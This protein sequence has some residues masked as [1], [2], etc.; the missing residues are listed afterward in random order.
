MHRPLWATVSLLLGWL[1]VFYSHQKKNGRKST[2]L[3]QKTSSSKM[4]ECAWMCPWFSVTAGNLVVTVA[5]GVR[6]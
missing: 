1:W 6:A 3:F 5:H 4:K 2:C